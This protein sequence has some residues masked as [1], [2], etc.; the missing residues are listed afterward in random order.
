[1]KGKKSKKR[2][3]R[4]WVCG[5]GRAEV[6]P[7][8]FHPF[9]NQVQKKKKLE[10]EGRRYRKRLLHPEGVKKRGNWRGKKKAGSL[11][12]LHFNS[13]KKKR[14]GGEKI[15]NLIR[16]FKKKRLEGVARNI[17]MKETKEKKRKGTSAIATFRTTS[18]ED[19]QEKKGKEK[20]LGRFASCPLSV[21]PAGGKRGTGKKR[22][23]KPCLTTFF[24]WTRRG[25]K[26]KK[27]RGGERR[28][29][30]TTISSLFPGMKEEREGGGPRGRERGR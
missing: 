17:L 26:D 25:G 9:L 8:D 14:R 3:G 7:F 22:R 2:G 15:T 24:L 28:T 4:L 6:H 29:V 10:G 5:R 23:K 16:T 11:L 13:E 21:R 18:G 12:P 20:S 30:A 1:M 19:L 27:K